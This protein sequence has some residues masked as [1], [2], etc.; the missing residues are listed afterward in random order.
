MKT[1]L[2]VQLF[3]EAALREK[4]VEIPINFINIDNQIKKKSQ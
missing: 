4:T 2:Y 3:N 1:R